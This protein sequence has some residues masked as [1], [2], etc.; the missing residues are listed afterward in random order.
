MMTSTLYA[1]AHYAIDL[2]RT[3]EI[4]GLDT[5]GFEYAPTWPGIVASRTA[6]EA[7]PAGAGDV[8]GFYEITV[9]DALDGD[10]LVEWLDEIE[11]DHNWAH[12]ACRL[13]FA[14][15]GLIRY[16]AH[17]V[18]RNHPEFVPLLKGEA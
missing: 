16:N 3:G 17:Q 5:V 7:C 10:A 4:A 12:P 6:R 1:V 11:W 9:P 15:A 14:S 8:V 2:G 13:L 18:A